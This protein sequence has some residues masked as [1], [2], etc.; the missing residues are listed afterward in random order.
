VIPGGVL[1][2]EVRWIIPG[3]LAPEMLEWFGSAAA[4]EIL[5]DVYLLDRI[6]PDVAIKVRAGS[7]LDVKV[8]AGR[9]GVVTT[10]G[11]THG[12]LGW[13]RTWSFP[14]RAVPE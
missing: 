4:S 6:G 11:G 5:R 2:L 1:S 8:S 14:L 12:R 13:W 10:P 7:Q 3:V 9:P